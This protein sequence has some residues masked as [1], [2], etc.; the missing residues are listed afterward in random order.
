VSS[1]DVLIEQLKVAPCDVERFCNSIGALDKRTEE[2]KIESAAAEASFLLDDAHPGDRRQRA[3]QLQVIRQRHTELF[4]LAA[5]KVALADCC[6][7]SV[8]AQHVTRS[9]L[10]G[11]WCGACFR[12]ASLLPSLPS[13]VVIA[14]SPEHACSPGSGVVVDGPRGGDH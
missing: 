8:S 13:S 10:R 12:V 7:K 6:F 14:R 9:L 11:M 2:L 1:A 3:E 4:A 5:E